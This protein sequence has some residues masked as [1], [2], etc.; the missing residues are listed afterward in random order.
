MIDK[1]RGAHAQGLCCVPLEGL[2][3]RMTCVA[4]A[5]TLSLCRLLAY[6]EKNTCPLM[7]HKSP[8]FYGIGQCY[9]SR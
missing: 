1:G 4:G 3:Y 7:S 2:G 5:A 6:P 8:E 9:R